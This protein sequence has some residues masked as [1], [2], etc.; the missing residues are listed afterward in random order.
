MEVHSPTNGKYTLMPSY[1][2]LANF[3]GHDVY[4]MLLVHRLQYNR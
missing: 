1:I 4:I 3:M 2:T